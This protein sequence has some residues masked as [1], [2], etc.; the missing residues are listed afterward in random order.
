MENIEKSAKRNRNDNF[1]PQ[2]IDLLLG[3]LE[4]HSVLIDSAKLDEK[5]KVCKVRAL[6]I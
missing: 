4:E 2:D 1:D 5:Q 3:L 6:K